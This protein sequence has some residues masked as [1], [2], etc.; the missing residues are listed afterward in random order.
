MLIELDGVIV[1]E[2]EDG[3]ELVNLPKGAKIFT[4]EMRCKCCLYVN[5]EEGKISCGVDGDEISE[6][7]T[8]YIYTE[9]PYELREKEISARAEEN[10]RKWKEHFDRVD[11]ASEEAGITR[12]QGMKFLDIYCSLCEQ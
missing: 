1:A 9:I 8:N 12:E 10:L 5:I 4:T 3:V 6:D 7:C 11:K 2:G